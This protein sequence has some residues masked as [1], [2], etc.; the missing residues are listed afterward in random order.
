MFSLTRTGLSPS[1]APLSSGL[2]LRYNMVFEGPTTP[3]DLRP[4]G[5]GSSP[6]ARHYSG[7]TYLVSFP[8]GTEMFHFP[9]FASLSGYPNE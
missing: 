3:Q 9:G 4:R 6:F 2:P 7:N 1:L 5:L 8:P